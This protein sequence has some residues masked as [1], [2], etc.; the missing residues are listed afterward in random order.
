MNTDMQLPARLGRRRRAFSLVEMVVASG[1]SALVFT[2]GAISYSV[3]TSQQRVS[4]TYGTVSIGSAAAVNYYGKAPS[5]TSID[6]YFAPNYGRAT[7]ADL[8]RETFYEDIN[9][10]S[11]V[12]CLPRSGLNTVRPSSLSLP[13]DQDGK[14]L[15]TPEKFRV[16]LEAAEPLLAGVHAP[17]EGVETTG[18]KNLSVYILHPGYATLAGT[19][20][21]TAIYEIDIQ[22]VSDPIGTYCSVRR[23]SFSILTDVYDV[24]YPF[25]LGASDFNPLV[26]NFERSVCTVSGL[27]DAADPYRIAE[28]EPFYFMWWPDPAVPSLDGDSIVATYADGDPLG[29]YG[30]MGG[31][32]SYMFTFPMFPSL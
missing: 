15:D 9:G 26:V 28:L 8:M 22:S 24:F 13:T 4:S 17:Y 3:I 1:I 6:A 11:A 21:V 14:S 31:R 32:T 27:D 30:K 23:Y 25:E 18:A 2:M 7:T 19:L 20:L 12:Y 29:G 5:V 16:F 10:A